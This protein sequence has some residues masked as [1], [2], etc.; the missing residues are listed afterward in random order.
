MKKQILFIQGGGNDG[1]EA[2]AKLV[3]Y[4]RAALGN[5]YEVHY[6]PMPSDVTLPDFGWT[7]QIAKEIALIDGDIILAGHSL[8]ASM[9]LKY[10]SENIPKIEISGVFLLA[11][12]FWTGDEKWVQGLKLK[13]DFAETLPIHI[14]M[15]FYH[16][17]DDEEVPFTHLEV[18]RQ[19]LPYARMI[20][21]EAG[22]HQL[23]NN[24][25]TLVNDIKLL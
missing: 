14:S 1:Y 8:G 6:P 15:F 9:L 25:S 19:K 2:D 13:S 3:N 4:L 24:L 17:R 20:E 5:T 23:N 21:F 7:Q 22:G 11:T 18:Y 16:C 10:L 12:P